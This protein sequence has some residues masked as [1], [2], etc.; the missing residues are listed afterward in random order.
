MKID[1]LDRQLLSLLAQDGRMTSAEM[2]RVVSENERKVAYRVNSLLQSGVISVL[3]IFNP[4]FFGYELIA[5][6]YCQV[7]LAKL[8]EVARRIAEFPEVRFVQA[9]FGDHDIAFQVLKK[10]SSE[11]Y[12]FVSTKLAG[13]P[14]IIKTT[15]TITATLFKDIHQWIPQEVQNGTEPAAE[16][17][18]SET[19][20]AEV[21]KIEQGK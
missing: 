5:D 4:E 14:G 1:D 20:S 2:A 19:V 21:E 3:G 15:T 18:V 9:V 7:E 16:V 6:V 13:V 8:N 12:N 17:E 10:S 11:L